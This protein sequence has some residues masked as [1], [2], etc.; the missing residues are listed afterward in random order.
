[1]ERQISPEREQAQ[2]GVAVD[3]ALAD[4]DEAA[5]EGQQFHSGP[6]RGAGERIEHDVHTVAIGVATDQLGEVRAARV[7]HMFY[8]PAAQQVSPLRAARGGVDLRSGRTCDGNRCLSYT[9]GP[10]MDQH[11]VAGRDPRELV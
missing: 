9:T 7:V 11:L 2:P 3:I 1:M 6:L 4:L 8:T 5:T 10:G